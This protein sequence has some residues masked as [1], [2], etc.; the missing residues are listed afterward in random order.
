MPCRSFANCVSNKAKTNADECCCVTA[1]SSGWQLA[2]TAW[3]CGHLPP[4]THLTSRSC[5]QVAS[6]VNHSRTAMMM[7][8]TCC[9][10]PAVAVFPDFAAAAAALVQGRPA[11]PAPRM[12]SCCCPCKCSSTQLLKLKCCR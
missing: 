10:S 1:A 4:T 12:M 3:L 8:Y 11:P 9:C 5:L 2:G 7:E 6:H